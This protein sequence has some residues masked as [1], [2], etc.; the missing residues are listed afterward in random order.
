MAVLGFCFVEVFPPLLPY[1]LGLAAGTM[2]HLVLAQLYPQCLQD[3]DPSMSAMTAVSAAA[4]FEALRMML[5]WVE[6][7]PG[8]SNQVLVALCWSLVAGL[9]TG[10]FK[11]H[12]GTYVLVFIYVLGIGGLVVACFK[13]L[14]ESL[15]AGLLGLAAGVMV[16]LSLFELIGPKLMAGDTLIGITSTHA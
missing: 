3:L 5:A 6:D 7:N 8:K 15:N 14:R 10:M 11:K 16:C 9:S 4:L 12:V 1:G 2:L 13:K